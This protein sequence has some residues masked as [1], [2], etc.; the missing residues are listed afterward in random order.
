MGLAAER[1]CSRGRGGG[2]FAEGTFDGGD[3]ATVDD[4]FPA[5]ED[6]RRHDFAA[7]ALAPLP[8]R[9]PVAAYVA[10]NV[11]NPLLGEKTFHLIAVRSAFAHEDDNR[12]VAG[13]GCLP[14]FGWGRSELCRR[15]RREKDK[16]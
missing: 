5:A 10:A 14:G 4:P 13:T 12:R 11:G 16:H 9:G 15:E 1:V 2:Y 7:V 6:H 8:E 3:V